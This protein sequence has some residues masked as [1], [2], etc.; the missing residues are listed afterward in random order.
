MNVQPLFASSVFSISPALEVYQVIIY[1]YHDPEG[2]Y[3]RILKDQ[4]ALQQEVNMI[5]ANMTEFLA[6]EKVFINDKRVNQKLLHV[7]IGLRGSPQIAYFQWIVHF[8]GTP[9]DGKNELSSD[10]EEELAEYDIDVLYLF[11]VGTR[12]IEVETPMEYVIRNPFLFVW[13]RKGDSVGGYEAV[14]FMLP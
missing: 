4:E 7:D 8:Q 12:I 13:G 10:V 6:A 2:V 3:E 11:P 5:Q 14:R 1:D 9:R